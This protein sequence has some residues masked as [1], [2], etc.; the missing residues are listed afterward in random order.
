[1]EG[2]KKGEKGSKEGGRKDDIRTRRVGRVRS[3]GGRMI[4]KQQG[5]V[6]CRVLRMGGIG[7]N[8]CFDVQEDEILEIKMI[9]DLS[10]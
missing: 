1:M 4:Q 3:G 7:R 5:C 2:R 6:L 9:Y 8:F 10:I